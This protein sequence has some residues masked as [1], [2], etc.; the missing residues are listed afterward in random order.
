[1]GAGL[2][3]EPFDE[4]QEPW[5]NEDGTIDEGLRDCYRT[6]RALILERYREG[7]VEST[8]NIPMFPGMTMSDIAPALREIYDRQ[9][10]AYKVNL[11]FGF[12]MWHVVTGQFR[13]FRPFDNVNVF[14]AP[15]LVS[16]R[17]DITKV[18]RKLKAL[19]IVTEMTKNRPDTKWK[20]VL[21]T[22]IRVKTYNTNFPLGAVSKRLLR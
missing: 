13:Y 2:H 17:D 10:H 11:S 16:T 5:L 7:P 18:L 9:S 22:N 8:Y 20:L 15:I 21:L 14:E 6:N 4:G 12:I 1:V 19:D 3:P